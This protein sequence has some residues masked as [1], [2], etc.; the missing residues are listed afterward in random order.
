[1]ILL[2]F[3]ID[4]KSGCQS[5]EVAGLEEILSSIVTQEDCC[6]HSI[7]QDIKGNGGLLLV[8]EWNSEAALEKHMQTDQFKLLTQTVEKVGKANAMSVAN[9]LS[10]GG[11]ELIEEQIVSLLDR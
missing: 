1:M 6:G 7:S 8:T 9:V 2:V 10:R 11:L 3:T 5:N 4:L